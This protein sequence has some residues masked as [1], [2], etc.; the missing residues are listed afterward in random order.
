MTKPPGLLTANGARLTAG[1][2]P[3]PPKRCGN[4]EF[5]AMVVDDQA[6]IECQGVPPIPVP[7]AAGQNL[8]G[9]PQMQIALFRPRLPPIQKRCGLWQ[10]REGELAIATKPNG[11]MQ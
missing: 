10:E 5:A 3:V 11:A 2:A 9:Q 6:M 8:A 1:P 7:M 4:C